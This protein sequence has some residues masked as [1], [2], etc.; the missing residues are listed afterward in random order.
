MKEF[1]GIKPDEERARRPAAAGRGRREAEGP[2]RRAPG[3]A[4]QLHQRRQN[5]PDRARDRGRRRR[6][7]LERPLA[8]PRRGVRCRRAVPRSK[9][10]GALCGAARSAARVVCGRSIARGATRAA[11][12]PP[13]SD[14]RLREIRL[15]ERP[16]AIVH[17]RFA[18]AWRFRARARPRASTWGVACFDGRGAER[19]ARRVACR[20]ADARYAPTRAPP[21]RWFPSRRARTRGRTRRRLSSRRMPSRPRSE[22]PSRRPRRP[23]RSRR[24]STSS[25]GTS[26]CRRPRARVGRGARRCC[27]CRDDQCVLRRVGRGRWRCRRRDDGCAAAAA[28]EQALR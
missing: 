15:N 11:A 10:A 12:A 17:S 4:R 20:A 19:S 23:T 24:T 21:D 9:R 3:R 6:G 13:T 2:D 25:P 28:I 16:E 7:P 8:C 14:G 22:G 1:V 18:R 26:T 27:P 5:A